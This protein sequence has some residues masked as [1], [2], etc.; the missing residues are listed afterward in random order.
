M[1]YSHVNAHVSF[2]GY[3]RFRPSIELYKELPGGF[4]TSFNAD[5]EWRDYAS[6]FPLMGTPREDKQLD[7][8]AAVTFRN[9]SWHGFAPKVQYTYTQNN[10][11]V[12]LY[13]YSSQ[14]LGFYLTKQY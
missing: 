11:N 3:D 8:T 5:Y 10:S 6:N 14:T 7:L 12:A 1:L 13:T 9:W 2:N 4:L